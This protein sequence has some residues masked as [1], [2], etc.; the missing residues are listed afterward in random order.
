MKSHILLILLL[1]LT[2]VSG[3]LVGY[4]V[5]SHKTITGLESRIASLDTKLALAE[6][7]ILALNQ[8]IESLENGNHESQT[9]TDILETLQGKTYWAYVGNMGYMQV[10]FG[11]CLNL[12]G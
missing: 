2:V 9:E 8:R 1:V 4:Q 7:T 11:A 12:G 10:R 3:V 5:S 6:S